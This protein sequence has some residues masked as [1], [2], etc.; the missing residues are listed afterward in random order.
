MIRPYSP[1]Y[2]VEFL[3]SMNV[4]PFDHEQERLAEHNRKFEAL[5]MFH[6]KEER[7]KSMRFARSL[8]G[9]LLFSIAAWV[10]AI[11]WCL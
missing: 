6:R 10:V 1:Y 2:E 8:A 3:K 5:V 4:V 7:E 11:V 9:A